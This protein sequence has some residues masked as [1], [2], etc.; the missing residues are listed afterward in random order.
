MK[1]R[2]VQYLEHQYEDDGNFK[3]YPSSKYNYIA[4]R[5]RD[6]WPFWSDMCFAQSYKE[7]AMKFIDIDIKERSMPKVIIHNIEA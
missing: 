1:Y 5:R 7:E 2:I 3:F 4:Q 6:W